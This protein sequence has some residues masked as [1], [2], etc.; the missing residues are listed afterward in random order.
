[1][2]SFLQIIIAEGPKLI[3]G[4]WSHAHES[5]LRE[6]FLRAYSLEFV[7]LEERQRQQP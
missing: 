1:M 3:A 7:S 2:A 6:G 4:G 5:G